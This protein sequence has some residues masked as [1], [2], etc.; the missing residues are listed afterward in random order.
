M[1][2]ELNEDRVMAML[3]ALCAASGVVG[4]VLGLYFC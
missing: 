3:V 2:E 1:G 4:V